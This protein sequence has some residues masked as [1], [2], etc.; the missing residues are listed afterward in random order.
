MIAPLRWSAL[1]YMAESPAHYRYY[2]DHPVEATPAMRFGALTHALVL[3]VAP[4]SFVVFDGVRRGNVWTEFKEAHGEVEIVS[5]EEWERA[6]A[7]ADAVKADPVCGKLLR[8]GIK[9]H[10]IEWSINGRS[11]MGTPDVNGNI[12]VDLKV[13][14][15]A[16]PNRLSWH[17]R[18]MQWHTQLAWYKDGIKAQG[19]YVEDVYLVTVTPK[20]PHLAV[21][22]GLTPDTLTLGSR[23]WQAL[24]ERLLVCERTDEWPGYAQDVIP[25][26]I[27]EDEFSLVIEGE[28]VSL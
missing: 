12:L 28:E 2:L 5:A 4:Q 13:T 9:E 19:G 14:P 25:L 1:R 26:D 20:P 7:C 15:F 3:G 8:S 11:C 21:A 27:E 16:N 10:R 6:S 24:F 22:Y 17:C 18:K 23:T